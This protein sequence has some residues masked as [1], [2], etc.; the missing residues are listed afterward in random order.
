VHPPIISVKA[1]NVPLGHIL[2]MLLLLEEEEEEEG[3]NR[4]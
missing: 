4:A 1:E 2:Q 3:S